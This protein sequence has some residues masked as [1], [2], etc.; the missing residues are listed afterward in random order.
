M[1][2]KRC[3]VFSYV[4]D[5]H[6]NKKVM[7]LSHHMPKIE[8]RTLPSLAPRC[9]DLAI[10]ETNKTFPVDGITGSGFLCVLPCKTPPNDSNI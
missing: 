7:P 6:P 9:S 8:D 2:G 1:G 3:K 5:K 4:F 10:E